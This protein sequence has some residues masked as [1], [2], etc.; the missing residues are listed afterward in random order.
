MET[1]AKRQVAGLPPVLIIL[2]VLAVVG[3]GGYFL[4]QSGKLPGPASSLPGASLFVPKATEKDFAFIEDPLI[5]KHFA[6]QANVTAFRSR[7]HDLIGQEGSFNVFEVQM[8]G[9]DAAFYNWREDAGKK[10]GELISIGDTTYVKD[11]KD[12]AWWKQTVKP[13]EKPKNEDEGEREPQNFAD[14]Y[15]EDQELTYKKLGE[16]SCGKLTCYKYEEVDP[17]NPEAK[18]IFWFDTQKLLLRKEESGFGE[19]RASVTYEYDSINIRAP[20]PTK[21]VP[22]GRNIYEYM[23]TGAPVN[24]PNYSP[25]GDQGE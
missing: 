14:E 21:D 7:S 20:S 9:N 1:M 25:A 5:R 10:G 3:G 16:E 19:W 12:G 23:G 15:K 22:E 18:R 13:E 2:I 11:Y 8:R 6:A 4:I 17:Q 24:I